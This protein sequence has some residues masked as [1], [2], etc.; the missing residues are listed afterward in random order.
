MRPPAV[1]DQKALFTFCRQQRRDGND[2]AA[3]QAL[4][5]ALR[6]DQLD[7]SG[8]LHAGRVLHQIKS[9]AAQTPRVTI[10][11][12]CTTSWL[13]P[14]LTAVARGRN[15]FL[16]VS[17][18]DYDNVMQG[19]EHL[20]QKTD[21]VILVP[22]TQRL[23]NED[24][25]SVDQRIRDELQFWQTAWSLLAQRSDVHLVQAGYD[26]VDAGS[27]GHFLGAHDGGGLNLVR[28]I[29]EQLRE[30]LPA[31]SYFVDLEQ[32]SGITGR[33]Q[34]YER[35]QYF[36]TKQ[37]FSDA[38][39]VR[40]AGHLWAGLRATFTGPKK[41]LVLDLDNTLWGGVVGEVGP[42]GVELGE[43]PAGEAF[44]DFQR[45]AKGLAQR[46]VL[47]A[48]CSKNNPEDA[49]GPFLEN[50]Q[51]VLALDDIVAFE[52]GWTPKAEVIRSIAQTLNL[53]LD[54]FVYFDDEPAERELVRQALP[55]VEVV[56]VPDDP[57][58]YRD[59]L[60]QGLW[61][62]AVSVSNED[63]M[64]T[65]QYRVEQERH[66]AQA[67]P[68]T[69]EDYLQSLELVGEIA[70]IDDASMDRVLQLIGKTNQFNLTTRR[71]TQ[72]TLARM[73]NS[74]S[75]VAL[76]LRARDRF[77]DYGLVAVLVA[78]SESSG[79]GETLRIDTWLMSCRII[80]RTAEQFIFNALLRRAKA[81]GYARLVGEY[82]PSRKNAVVA[83]LYER[84]GFTATGASAS[85]NLFVLDVNSAAP[86]ATFF[87]A[88]TATQ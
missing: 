62:E 85:G 56:N 53:G 32:V 61:F 16:N 37:P 60:L 23:M 43:T 19:I 77:G 3:A 49:R 40:V 10:L 5:D 47:I 48:V 17:D 58:A 26:W 67:I 63:R 45:L 76:T 4:H 75:P 28:Q 39:L 24:D 55:E 54:S 44:R 13:V 6:R 14:A 68:A 50:S 18:A 22:W 35:R 51:M 81:L 11:G 1:F 79:D 41:V 59:A 15:Q 9:P 82:I 20:D 73:L 87:T 12:Q 46:G 34:F 83:D 36:W 71:H 86:A 33:E 30:A 27:D 7:P 66:K 52:A 72:D 64:R 80:G 78:I 31:G 88:N 57:A 65:E 21:A 84:L 38:G 29:N 8:I 70:T 42:L 74:S 69:V 25:R 2:A